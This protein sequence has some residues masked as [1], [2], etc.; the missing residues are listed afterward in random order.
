M[1]LSLAFFRDEERRKRK[2]APRIRRR[3]RGLRRPRF[4]GNARCDASARETVAHCSAPQPRAQADFFPRERK[5][6]EKSASQRATTFGE[7]HQRAS[8]EFAVARRRRPLPN[9]TA[10]NARLRKGEAHGNERRVAERLHHGKIADA[11]ANS[12]ELRF[13]DRLAQRLVDRKFQV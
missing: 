8:L 2:C 7:A 4:C 12:S 5:I 13:I 1:F 6:S 9:E 11:P 3:S 10:K